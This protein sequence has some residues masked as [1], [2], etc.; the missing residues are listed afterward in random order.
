M[1]R[2][3]AKMRDEAQTAG[4][5][6]GWLVKVDESGTETMK[7]VFENA[8]NGNVEEYDLSLVAFNDGS[9]QVIEGLN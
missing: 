9:P 1:I 7:I 2:R 8:G 4:F 5:V 6:L 3:K